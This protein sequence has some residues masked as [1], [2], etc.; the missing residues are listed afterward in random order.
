MK[1]DIKKLIQTVVKAMNPFLKY[2]VKC[3]FPRSGDPNLFHILGADVIFDKDCQPWLLELNSHPSMAITCLDA[4]KKEK[5]ISPVDLHVKSM[6]MGHAVKLCLK[7]KYSI[8]KYEEYDSYTQVYSPEFDK[9][10]MKDLDVVE[11]FFSLFLVLAGQKF[12]PQLTLAKF[13]KMSKILRVMSTE[14]ISRR[15]LE[16]IYNNLMDYHD[17]MDFYCFLEAIDSIIDLMNIGNKKLDRNKEY[18]LLVTSFEMIED[19]LAFIA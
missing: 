9:N 16:V 18:K 7:S 11:N 13:L 6:V 12:Y 19:K 4:E 5:M 15:E 3:T 17:Q 10:F 2:F 8:E 14:P 1:K